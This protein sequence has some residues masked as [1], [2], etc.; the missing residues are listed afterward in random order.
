MKAEVKGA[1]VLPVQEIEGG[2]RAPGEDEKEPR[3][4]QALAKAITWRGWQ[5]GRVGMADREIAPN[6]SYGVKPRG[7]GSKRGVQD[8]SG[9]T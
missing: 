7:G 9:I 5:G 1:C 4:H 6:R 3:A 8:S 2:M